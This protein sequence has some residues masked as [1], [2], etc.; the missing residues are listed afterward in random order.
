MSKAK[1]ANRGILKGTLTKCE[2]IDFEGKKG[3][4]Q[5]LALEVNTGH[6]NKVQGTVFNTNSN[7]T[8]AQDFKAQYREGVNVKV[9]GSVTEREF[10]SQNGKKGINRGLNVNSIAFLEDGESFNSTFILQ[11]IV[12]KIKETET[13]AVVILTIDNSYKNE[14]QEL[15]KREDVF[16]LSIDADNLKV[17]DKMDV[18]K[19]CNA[20]FKG[21]IINKLICDDYGDVINSAQMFLIKEVE[22]VIQPEDLE[23]DE[24]KAV[25]DFLK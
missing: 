10:E 8:K 16:N 7:P 18:C 12:N 9:I 17:L 20:K 1:Y 2:L 21:L 11:G 19:G 23:P 4:G 5:F 6:G 13:G 25:L 14:N 22:N 3:K 24:E 15:V